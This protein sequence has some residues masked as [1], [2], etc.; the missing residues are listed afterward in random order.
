MSISYV[1]LGNII[2]LSTV[3]SSDTYAYF[4]FPVEAEVIVEY[5]V[6]GG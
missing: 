3:S 1:T 2:T 6:E 4:E 5:K